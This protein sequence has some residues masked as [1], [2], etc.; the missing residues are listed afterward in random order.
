MMAGLCGF[1]K[2]SCDGTVPSGKDGKTRVAVL[3][4]TVLELR[5]RPYAGLLRTMSGLDQS[6]KEVLDTCAVIEDAELERK[7]RVRC[8]LSS[9]NSLS[10]IGDRGR[11]MS[12]ILR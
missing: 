4:E 1:L 8:R 9:C 6:D 3:A 2:V 11:S 5:D 10:T 7:G 12:G